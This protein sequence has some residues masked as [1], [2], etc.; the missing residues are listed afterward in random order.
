M[1]AFN[2]FRPFVE[3][4]AEGNID[5][6]GHVIKLALSNASPVNTNTVI[7]DITQ[8]AN[9]NGYTTGGI[10]LTLTSSAQ[11]AGTYS[12]KFADVTDAWVAGPSAMAT[13]RYLIVYDS[14]NGNLIGW[15]DAGVAITLNLGDSINLDLDDTNGIF[16]IA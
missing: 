1:V 2:K 9:G 15:W 10:T 5:M 11:S 12:A 4:L 14:T 13:F 8:I 7:G 16:T 3:N 6:D